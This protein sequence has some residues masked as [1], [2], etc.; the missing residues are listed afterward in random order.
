MAEVDT[1]PKAVSR[2]F[3]EYTRKAK[4]RKQSGTVALNILIDD[5]GTVANVKLLEGIPD[6]TLNE[7]TME[8]ARTWRYKPA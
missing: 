8:T 6:S 7:T 5:K 1:P 2:P 3:P 4:K